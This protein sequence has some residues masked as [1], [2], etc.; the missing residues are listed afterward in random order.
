MKKVKV[1]IVGAGS[2]SFGRGA[3]VDLLSSTELREVDLEIWLVDIDQDA[4]KRMLDLSGRLKE[5]FGSH[6][7]IH[8]TPDRREA[9]PDADYVVV[10]VARRRYQL[11]EQDFRVPLA[12]GFKHVDG[13]NGGPG[14]AFHT[15]RSTHLVVPI[16]RD[17]ETLCPEALLI[18]FTN[19]ESRV[20]LAV[21]KLT[22]I[23]AIGLCHGAF[24]TLRYVANVLDRPEEEI[25]L[26]I[27]GINHFHWVLSVRSATSGKS[28]DRALHKALLHKHDTLDPT[29]A[30][31]F[32][33]FGRL[34]FPA[35]AHIAEYVS[36]GHETCGLLWPMGDEGRPVDGDWT[37]H[38]R[39]TAAEVER[40]RRAA[41]GEEPLGEAVTAT[42]GELTVPIICDIEFDRDRRE[43]SVNIPNEGGAISNLP[44]DAIVEIPA[45]VNR[46]GVHGEKVGAL[47]EP[48]AALCR[49][50]ITI[51][52]LLVEA[53]SRQSREHLLQALVL[54]PVVDS[55][56]RARG[57]M[58][59]LLEVEAD[60]LPELH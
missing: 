44:D 17:M 4:L 51:Q 55:V 13:E 38:R 31:M 29:V 7:R 50:Q 15:L 56:D 25:D 12:F 9:L 33:L 20:C 37:S 54:D 3:V 27:G 60:F 40:V 8:G 10:S 42:S 49:T 2:A 18:N 22:T 39:R 28:L 59:M 30:R 57:M 47:P 41:S 48:I 11:W 53:Y 26:T 52:N 34:P 21:S 6:A 5:H 14:A 24:G 36:W 45:R 32:D 43:L 35:A 16:C 46:S 58:D 19:P 1:V 23:K